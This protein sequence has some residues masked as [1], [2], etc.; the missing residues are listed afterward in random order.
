[1]TVQIKGLE[2]YYKLLPKN[3]SLKTKYQRLKN[4]FESYS[5]N[6]DFNIKKMK[7]LKK[8]FF[9]SIRKKKK[10]GSRKGSEKQKNGRIGNIS[11]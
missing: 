5:S 4:A 2:Q 3:F 10:I 1:M 9:L 7:W 11:R 8:F 6:F